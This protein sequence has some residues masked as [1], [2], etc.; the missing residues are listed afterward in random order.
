MNDE[1]IDEL[2]ARLTQSEDPWV[3]RKQSFNEREV[4][5]TAVG[6]AN[7]VGEGQKAVLFIG[8]DN[9]GQHKGEPDADGTQK[10]I[11]GILDRCYPRIEYQ[12]CVFSIELDGKKVEI[13]AVLV[14]HSKNRP[15]FA[16]PAYVRRGS[17]TIEA[18]P[19]MFRELVASQ[20]DKARRLLQSKGDKV[21]LRITSASGFWYEVE[22]RIETCDAISLNVV[23]TYGPMVHYPLSIEKIDVRQ[24]SFRGLVIEAKPD[25]TEQEHLRR[26]IQQWADCRSLK[27]WPVVLNVNDQTVRQLLADPKAA[28]PAVAALADGSK[29]PWLKLLL[30]EIRFAVKR[31]NSPMTAEQKHIR[32]REAYKHWFARDSIEGPVNAVLEVASSIHEAHQ[33]LESAIKTY[34]CQLQTQLHSLLD[35]KLGLPKKP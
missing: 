8:A 14:P 29:N 28:I 20:N 3:E 34:D 4:R 5:K 1:L 10:K 2:K 17:E 9:R 15:H 7:S 24:E 23:Q 35:M 32:F 27:E 11:A 6:F 12:T 26:M 25:C 13:L 31:I 22:G 21:W 19:E 33:L 16:G 30:V 18:S